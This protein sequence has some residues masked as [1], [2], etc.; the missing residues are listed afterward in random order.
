MGRSWGVWTPETLGGGLP[1]TQ[2][3]Q[4][5][6]RSVSES[7]VRYVIAM[8]FWASLC[9]SSPVRRPSFP[10]HGQP[11]K[12]PNSRLKLCVDLTQPGMANLLPTQADLLNDF[13][14]G[15]QSLDM[16]KLERT[17][18]TLVI[19]TQFISYFATYMQVLL[20]TPQ[21][22][23]RLKY[24]SLWNYIKYVLPMNGLYMCLRNNHPLERGGLLTDQASYATY[25]EDLPRNV[26]T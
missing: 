3:P 12:L 9:S 10:C 6:T 25:T 26:G 5:S 20:C 7:S 2:L 17:L 16:D 14:P 21:H 23:Q 4:T 15:L 11:M 18:S 22:C 19:K 1:Y 13:L 24:V 8:D